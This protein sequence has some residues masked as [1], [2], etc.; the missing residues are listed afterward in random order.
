[1]AKIKVYFDNENYQID[2]SSFSDASSK[3]QSHLSNVMN[4]SGATIKFGGTSYNIDSTKLQNATNNFTSHLGTIAG[5]GR[6]VVVNG[7]EYS[8]DSGKVQGA[9]TELKA[10]LG[11]LHSDEGDSSGEF[12]AGLYQ[13]GAIALYDE[14]GLKAIEGMMIKSWDELLTEGVVHVNDGGVET[15]PIRTSYINTSSDILAGDLFIPHDGSITS[16]NRYGFWFCQNLTGV[17]IPESV[18]SIGKEA[19]RATGIINITIPDSV[20]SIDVNLFHAS[21]SLSSVNLSNNIY[22]KA[23]MFRHCKNLKSVKLNGN[24][25]HGDFVEFNCQ[26]SSIPAYCFQGCTSIATM[27]IP[28]HVTSTADYSLDGCTSLSTIV[29]KGTVEQWNTIDISVFGNAPIKEV[30]CSDGTITL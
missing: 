30:I 22:L 18:T 6:K 10:V 3:L 1:M 14:Q 15:N 21:Q 8:I 7:V 5:N 20:V 29:Y 16:I 25:E 12:V 2:E 27:V 4:G 24:T 17:K 11:N 9:V 26:Y 19:F 13:T 28:E 23:S